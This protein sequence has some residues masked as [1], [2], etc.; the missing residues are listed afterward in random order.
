MYIKKNIT[1]NRSN[2]TCRKHD[3]VFFVCF[4]HIL[5]MVQKSGDH[6]LGCVIKLVE[7][8]IFTISTG[9]PDFF[10]QQYLGDW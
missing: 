10:H 1:P 5:L 6:H 8:V 2:G 7:H 3:Q 4:F 9:E